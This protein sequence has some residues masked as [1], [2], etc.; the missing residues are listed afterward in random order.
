MYRNCNNKYVYTPDNLSDDKCNLLFSMGFWTSNKKRDNH[1]F[2]IDKISNFRRDS[3]VSQNIKEF[4]MTPWS[5]CLAFYS[6]S[7]F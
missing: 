6:L 4:V 2:S 7:L 1:L 5:L 3:V